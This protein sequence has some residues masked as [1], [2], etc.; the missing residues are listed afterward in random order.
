MSK[1]ITTDKNAYIAA[2]LRGWYIS[3]PRSLPWRIKPNSQDWPNPYQIWLA[4]IMAQQTTLKVVQRYYLDF[5][6]RWPTLEDLAAA[7]DE[8]I[9]S[10][11]AGLGYYSR[12]R[13]MI[14]CAKKLMSDYGGKLPHSEEELLKLPGIG[15]YSAAAIA[16][17]AYGQ[18]AVVVDGNVERVFTRL[19]AI[20]EPL[21]K[22]RK[23]IRIHVGDVL[24]KA[25]E[26]GMR[27]GDYA[28]AC[29]DF[30]GRLCKPRN[31]DCKHCPI[32]AH[33]AASEAPES[34]P[35]KIPKPPRPERYTTMFVLRNTSGQV[36]L[37]RRPPKGLLGGM[38]GF[39]SS[40]WTSA[41]GVLNHAGLMSIGLNW[42]ELPGTV[43]HTFT[44][45]RLT[46]RIWTAELQTDKLASLT[47][48]HSQIWTSLEALCSESNTK[49]L[50]DTPRL[51]SLMLKVARHA[52]MHINSENSSQ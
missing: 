28:Q 12:A 1:A 3:N 52:L 15:P 16:A 18:P 8:E 39:P 50:Q 44:H 34:F 40:E 25:L 21:P 19:F 13:N 22:A 42:R 35:V 20:P 4:E 26:L 7:D 36:L 10:A 38:P 30:G 33:C 14:A 49:P 6:R 5:I 17:V 32:S 46:S 11:W 45:F 43:V 41:D 23:V 48:I 47:D 31:P 51:P 37:E 9:L 2:G 29:M 27:S 24:E